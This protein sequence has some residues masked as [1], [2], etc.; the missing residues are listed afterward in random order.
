MNEN[1]QLDATAIA[2]STK[3][4]PLRITETRPINE[5]CMTPNLAFLK[6]KLSQHSGRNLVASKH[7]HIVLQPQLPRD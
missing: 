7:P 3:T 1:T 5:T 4:L 6:G 2:A